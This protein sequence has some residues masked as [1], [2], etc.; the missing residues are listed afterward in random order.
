MPFIGYITLSQKKTDFF[1]K[2]FRLDKILQLIE[3]Y[4]NGKRNNAF[5]CGNI[6][7]ILNCFRVPAA[8]FGWTV[9]YIGFL[10]HP[11]NIDGGIGLGK[12]IEPT[13]IEE[14]KKY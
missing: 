5:G 4:R 10:A 11:L 3:A 6:I 12:L 2:N 13:F 14:D 9:P 1:K 7:L 8:V